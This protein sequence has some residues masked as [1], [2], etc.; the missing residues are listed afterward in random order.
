VSEKPI[1]F[2]KHAVMR[3]IAQNLTEDLAVKA[4]KEGKRTREGKNKYK[5][6]LRTKH[7]LIVA[8]YVDYS[9]HIRII[10][11]TKGGREK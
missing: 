5:A 6:A 3:L 2:T 4:V 9:D 7:G 8:I 11:V 10:T 1:L